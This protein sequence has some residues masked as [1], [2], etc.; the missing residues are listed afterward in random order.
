MVVTL[1]YGRIESDHPKLIPV[2]AS[3]LAGTYLEQPRHLDF[4][5]SYSSLEH[6]GLGRVSRGVA[7]S[8]V[9]SLTRHHPTHSTGT[10]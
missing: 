7:V 5:V 8:N 1:E 2:I 4:V 3:E 9:P 10:R 6:S